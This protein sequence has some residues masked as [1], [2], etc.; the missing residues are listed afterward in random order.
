[1]ACD[2]VGDTEPPLPEEPEK[3]RS[4]CIL[5]LLVIYL[6]SSFLVLTPLLFLFSPLSLPPSLHSHLSGQWL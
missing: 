1:M 2:S 4:F 6:M 5:A 3:V